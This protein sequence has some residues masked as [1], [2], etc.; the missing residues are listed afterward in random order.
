MIKLSETDTGVTWLKQ[1]DVSD[2]AAAADFIDAMLL[3]SRDEFFERLRALI[4]D[5]AS[6]V[7]GPIGLYAEREICR[8]SD[9][10]NHLFQ[11]DR[12]RAFG[13]GPSPVQPLQGNNPQVGSE[14]LVATL[15][16]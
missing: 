11:E 7:K 9:I 1:F 12:G 10:P 2:Q 4:L 15:I 14:G 5:R 3:V 8:D 6:Q 13:A 16:T